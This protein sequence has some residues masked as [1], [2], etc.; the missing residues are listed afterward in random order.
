[1]SD[2]FKDEAVG[3][4]GPLSNASVVTPSDT[5]DLSV[6]SR[7]IYV[8]TSGDV[9]I[10]LSGGDTVVLK[11]VAAGMPLPIRA[12]RVHATNTTATDIV[13]LW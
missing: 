8:G 2:P 6:T 4:I 11:N 7:A 5:T 9:Q 10:T 1:M 3:V 12:E 13:A